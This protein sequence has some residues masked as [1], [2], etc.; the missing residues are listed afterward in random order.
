MRELAPKNEYIRL[1]DTSSSSWLMTVVKAL[2][3]SPP[4]NPRRAN[5]TTKTAKGGARQRIKHPPP[6]NAAASCT[7]TSFVLAINSWEYLD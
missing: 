3:K 7:Q 6:M 4:P 1:M 2:S 5:E